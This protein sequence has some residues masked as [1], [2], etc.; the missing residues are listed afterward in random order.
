MKHLGRTLIGGLLFLAVPGAASAAGFG[1]HVGIGSG[2]MTIDYD[3]G[4]GVNEQDVDADYLQFGFTLDTGGDN[5]LFKYRLNAGYHALEVEGASDDQ[6]GIGL[7]NHF[8][9]VFNRGS[10]VKV[11]AGP[12][13]YLGLL[14]GDLGDGA[15]FGFGPTVGVDIP[16]G[17][18]PTLGLELSWRAA[19]HA[20]DD[21][22]DIATA[23]SEDIFLRAAF[24]F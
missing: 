9:F 13:V 10:N 15:Y 11:W 7:D 16:L 18:G 17:N 23:T 20:Y 6:T 2:T 21:I 5:S 4:F 19:G 14:D 8:G 24:M 12:S 22:D 3:S 1:G